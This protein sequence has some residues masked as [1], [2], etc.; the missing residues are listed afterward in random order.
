MI[1][2][3]YYGNSRN[4]DKFVKIGISTSQPFK[5]E[6]I[7][8]LFPG[9]GIV[10]EYKKNPDKEAYVSRYTEEVLDKTTPSEIISKIRSIC[11]KN[12]NFNVVLLCYEKSGDFCHRHLVAE[13]LRKSGYRV[14]EL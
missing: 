3:S 12:H 7:P 13:W 9:W 6:T 14:S 5:V 1:Y 2:T 4:L 8:E 11:I 10:S